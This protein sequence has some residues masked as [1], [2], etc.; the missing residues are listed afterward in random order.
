MT[1]IMQTIVVAPDGDHLDVISTVARASVL[2]LSNAMRTPG[3]MAPWREWL[4][5]PFAKVVKRTSLA[6]V[7]RLASG[8]PGA[9]LHQ[10]RRAT[11]VALP[12]MQ[13]EDRPLLAIKAQAAGL[14]REITSSQELASQG[15]VVMMDADL[16]MSTGKASAQAAH[17]AMA[18]VLGLHLAPDE[19][20]EF[21][22]SLGFAWVPRDEMQA[23]MERAGKSFVIHDAGR[24]EITPGSLTAAALRVSA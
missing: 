8:E 21:V 19:I 14:Q 5:G 10:G 6:K 9:V 16:G 3:S 17:A 23:A 18:A 24:T 4:N 15:W 12:P 13:P 22:A 2:C 1:S 11:A 20:E 7:E